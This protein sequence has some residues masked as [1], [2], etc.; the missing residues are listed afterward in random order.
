VDFDDDAIA[1]ADAL[2]GLFLEHAGQHGRPAQHAADETLNRACLR[3]IFGGDHDGADLA[4]TE[5][6]LPVLEA[7]EKHRDDRKDEA[8]TAAAANDKPS[9]AQRRLGRRAAAG[10]L[11]EKLQ[12]I[13]SERQTEQRGEEDASRDPSVAPEVAAKHRV[14]VDGADDVGSSW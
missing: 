6:G 8:L 12:L 3:A 9:L 7:G 2:G 14:V 4:G 5:V 10:E 11:L 1:K 13:I